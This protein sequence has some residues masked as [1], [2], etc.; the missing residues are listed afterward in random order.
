[1]CVN[2]L[3]IKVRILLDKYLSDKF[4]IHNS[5]ENK[6]KKKSKKSSSSLVFNIALEYEKGTKT[7]VHAVPRLNGLVAGFQPRRPRVRVQ[8]AFGVV[9]Q[10]GT[11]T[12][13]L[14]VL[15][16]PLPIIPPISPSS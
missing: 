2:E 14:R 3:Y 8:V 1:M 7:K 13:F 11:G 6:T 15:Q 4:S 12:G 16:F 9:G 5:L 10:S